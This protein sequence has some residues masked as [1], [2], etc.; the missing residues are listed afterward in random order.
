M[1][2]AVF[3]LFG[4][5]FMCV[6]FYLDKIVAWYKKRRQIA[7]QKRDNKTN[8]KKSGYDLLK[9]IVDESVTHIS[10]YNT[11][12]PRLIVVEVIKTFGEV[13]FHKEVRFSPYIFERSD[14]KKEFFKILD[15]SI[16]DHKWDHLEQFKKAIKSLNQMIYK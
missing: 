12:S 14:I 11:S 13:K 16:R 4:A 3:F 5:L 7:K 2:N 6:C 10:I 1:D 9:M 8:L 15:R